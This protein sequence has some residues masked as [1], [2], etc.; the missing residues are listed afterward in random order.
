MVINIT[1]SNKKNYNYDFPLL[2]KNGEKYIEKKM[3]NFGW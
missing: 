3:G 1:K 2:T